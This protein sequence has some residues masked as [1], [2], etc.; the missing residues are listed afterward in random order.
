M[1]TFSDMQTTISMVT[2]TARNRYQH[3]STVRTWT[4][5]AIARLQSGEISI[6]DSMSNCRYSRAVPPDPAKG[7]PWDNYDI[8]GNEQTLNVPNTA[9]ID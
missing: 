4:R 5:M 8:L 2:T 3:A 1:Q 6:R 7:L 9:S